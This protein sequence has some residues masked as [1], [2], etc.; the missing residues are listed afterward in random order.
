MFW[1]RPAFWFV[2]AIASMLIP[3]GAASLFEIKLVD[4]ARCTLSDMLC[5]KLRH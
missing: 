4:P 3:I 2:A 5:D 1:L